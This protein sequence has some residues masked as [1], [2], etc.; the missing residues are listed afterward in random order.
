[1]HRSRSFPW[2]LGLEGDILPRREGDEACPNVPAADAGLECFSLVN[3][4]LEPAQ[5]LA[6]LIERRVGEVAAKRCPEILLQKLNK[7]KVAVVVGMKID[8]MRNAT[9]GAK[10]VRHRMRRR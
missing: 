10:P 3:A 9:L 7:P 8:T 2:K 6:Y 5:K 4:D 1:V